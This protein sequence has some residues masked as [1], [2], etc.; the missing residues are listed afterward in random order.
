V[1]QFVRSWYTAACHTPAAIY[2][3]D[4][5]RQRAASLLAQIQAS[6][7]L[8]SLTTA[9]L[10]LTMLAI[11]HYNKATG[12]LPRDRARLYD[13]CVTLLLERWEPVRTPELTRPGLLERLEIDRLATHED[14]RAVMH[15]VAFAAHDR[16]PD[17]GDGRGFVRG[18]ELEGEMSRLLRRL[19]CDR[20]AERLQEFEQALRDETGLLQEVGDDLYSFPHL[21]F[22]EFLA[23]CALADHPHM[24]TRAYRVWRSADGDRWREVL[25]LL[26]G[27]LRQQRKVD[28]QG[29]GWLR[30]LLNEQTPDG[31]PKSGVQRGRDALLA[32]DCY[33]EWEGRVALTSFEDEEARQLEQRLACALVPLLTSVPPVPLNDRRRAGQHLAALGDPRPGVCTLEPDWCDVPAGSFLLGSSDQDEQADADEKPQRTVDLPGFRIARYPVTNAQWQMFMDAGGYRERRWWSEAGWQAKEER[34]WTEPRYR[35][36]PRF[37]GNNQ[38]VVGITWYEAN[39]FCRWLSD[40]LGYEVRLPSEAEWEQAARGSDGRIYPW[41]NDW[42]ANRANTA[43]GG[44]RMTTPVGCYPDGAGPSGALDMSGNVF[45]W[46]AT[47]WTGNYEQS[48]STARETEDGEAFVRRGGAW[49]YHQWSARCAYRYASRPS[50]RIYDL[51][52]RVCAAR[53]ESDE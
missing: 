34:G 31:Q 45:E 21:T 29:V 4:E 20:I 10:L 53:V 39:T 46:T 23:A 18:S 27:R 6:E 5:G 51:G 36:D 26:M 22:Q 37:N 33:A 41:G 11:L 2:P 3:P 16:P 42:D 30:A 35:D 19:R 40:A 14:L 15:T 32:A 49:S 48:D 25:L 44:I 43:E 1:R 38:P 24:V 17:P 7:R 13:E 9:P 52:L 8:R 50:N 28:L 47:P 12:E